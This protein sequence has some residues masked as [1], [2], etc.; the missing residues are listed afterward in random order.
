MHCIYLIFSRQRYQAS[1]TPCLLMFEVAAGILPASWVEIVLRHAKIAD[2]STKHGLGA[3]RALGCSYL[4][5]TREYSPPY[6]CGK[7]CIIRGTSYVLEKR[8]LARWGLGKSRSV[9]LDGLG[10]HLL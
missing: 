4:P 9:C 6:P 3:A 8:V 10:P 5:R 2:T 1:T 7:V